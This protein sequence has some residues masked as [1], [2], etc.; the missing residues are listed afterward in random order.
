MANED[1]AIWQVQSGAGSGSEAT[2]GAANTILFNPNPVISSG[3]L[4]FSQEF[5][6]RNSTPENESVGANNNEIEDMGI[7]GVDIQITGTFIAK[8]VNF[9]I[10]RFIR[11]MK[12][13]KGGVEVV[14]YEEGR[15]G[16]RLNNFP[17]FNVT[18]DGNGVAGN[19]TF[20]YVLASIKFMDDAAELNRVGFVATLRLAGDLENAI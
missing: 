10:A 15:F 8:D 13:P 2:A 1:S 11:F 3:G 20:G 6:F 16:L 12:E 9:S 5:D 4:I 18:P 19:N 17:H 14:G 7:D